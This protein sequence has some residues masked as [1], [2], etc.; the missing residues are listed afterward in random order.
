[1]TPLFPEYQV[2]RALL[3]FLQGKSSQDYQ[4]MYNAIWELTGTP[5]AT[6]DWKNGEPKACPRL[7]LST[8][9]A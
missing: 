3:T 6:V 9:E 7:Q 4:D 1:M 5:Q 8:Q 2:A